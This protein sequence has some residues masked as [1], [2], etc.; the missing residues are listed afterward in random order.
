MPQFG[1]DFLRQGQAILSQRAGRELSL[2]E[3]EESAT[4]LIGFFD[5]LARWGREQEAKEMSDG[6]QT[7]D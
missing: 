5:T 2:P 7:T 3:V 4:N 6:T 1:E